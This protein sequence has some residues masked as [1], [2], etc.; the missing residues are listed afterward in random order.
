MKRTQQLGYGIIGALA[1]MAAAPVANAADVYKRDGGLKDGPVADYGPPIGWS[2]FYV[3]INAGA[4]FDD[5]NVS[6]DDTVGLLGGHI[7]YNW[8]GGSPWVVG[9]EGDVS[10]LDDDAI[11]YLA[12]IRGRLGYAFG[13][14]LL[15]GTAGAA[16]LGVSEDFGGDDLTGFVAG[17]G[18]ERKL[19]ENVSFGVEALYYSFDD[20][21]NGDEADFWTARARLT[22]HFG[23][24]DGGL[25]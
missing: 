5:S 15:Y 25:K 8:Q 10:Y 11:D 4:A 2:G 7:G 12:T 3:G 1:L 6:E 9:I 23:R 13:P 16:F 18:F 24:R 20:N 14:T 17:G 22:Y 21:D 19:R